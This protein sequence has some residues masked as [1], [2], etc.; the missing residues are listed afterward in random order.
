M[1]DSLKSK[2]K[3]L[4]LKTY[5]RR[6]KAYMG[7]KSYEKAKADFEQ[8]LSLSKDEKKFKRFASGHS[9]A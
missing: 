8:V 6:A 5:L 9:S 1:L 4:K 2:D 7:M 3:S